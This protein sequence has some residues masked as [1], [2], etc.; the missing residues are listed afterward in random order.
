MNKL[1]YT[2]EDFKEMLVRLEP[3]TGGR[4]Q[5][6]LANALGIQQSSISDAMRRGDG[7]PDG[8]LITLLNN[9]SLNPEWVKY[10]TGE[11]CL[12]P[13]NNRP[14]IVKVDDRLEYLTPE[15]LVELLQKKLGDN[16]HINIS[17]H[18]STQE[19]S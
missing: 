14:K 9:Y 18:K 1:A 15:V 11:K 4:T 12:I 6:H 2:K 19:V 16:A 7:P 13:A 17:Y 8:W 3:I 5:I 10:G